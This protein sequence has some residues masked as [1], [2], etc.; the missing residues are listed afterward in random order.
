MLP[1]LLNQDGTNLDRVYYINASYR[2]DTRTRGWGFVIGNDTGEIECGGAGQINAVLGPLQAES[3]A[4]L[5]A[6]R[7][8]AE[9]GMMTIEVETDC[10]TLKNALQSTNWDA[11]PGRIIFRELKFF[12]RTSFNDVLLLYAPRSSNSVAHTLAQEG[13]TLDPGSSMFW[14]VR[15]LAFV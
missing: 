11:A 2:E 13:I 8:A 10:Q 5:Q 3:M 14:L 15:F 4:C 9:Q 1:L 6:L 12:I 7:A